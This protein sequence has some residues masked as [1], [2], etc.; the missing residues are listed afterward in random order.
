MAPMLTDD[1]VADLLQHMDTAQGEYLHREQAQRMRAL[2]HTSY[3]RQMKPKEMNESAS[4]FTSQISTETVLRIAQ[5]SVHGPTV[6]PTC[7]NILSQLALSHRESNQKY[8]SLVFLFLNSLTPMLYKES[9]MSF[10]LNT[11]LQAKYNLLH[12]LPTSAAT[13]P[14]AIMNLNGKTPEYMIVSAMLN[15]GHSTLSHYTD[16][17]VVTIHIKQEMSREHP[18]SGLFTPTVCD[19]LFSTTQPLRPVTFNKATLTDS[20]HHV[21]PPSSQSSRESRAVEVYKQAVNLMHTPP[22]QPSTPSLKLKKP[23][24]RSSQVYQLPQYMQSQQI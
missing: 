17:N 11:L 4:S 14:P 13:T 22:L 6:D 20:P 3:V 15:A 10:V 24:P 18:T 12:Q 21:S 8:E 7:I 23:V 16:N 5:A 1:I 9:P 2:K 19:E